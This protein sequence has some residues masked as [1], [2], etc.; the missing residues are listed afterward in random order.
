MKGADALECAIC[1]EDCTH[2]TMLECAHY[3]CKQCFEQYA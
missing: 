1:R 2:A 3:F